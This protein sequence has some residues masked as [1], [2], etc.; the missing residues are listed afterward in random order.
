MKGYRK[1]VI[2]GMALAGFILT[3]WL[4]GLTDSGSIVAVGSQIVLLLTA[5]IYGNVKEHEAE[6]KP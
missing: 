4:Q 2:F 6:K 5:A 1:V 3:L